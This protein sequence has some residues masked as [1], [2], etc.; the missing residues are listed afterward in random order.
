[1]PQEK[2]KVV[3]DCNVYLQ[4]F[5]SAKGTAG[6]RKKLVD[7]GLIELY[8]SRDIFDEVSNVLARPEFQAKFSHATPEAMADFIEKVN[9]V[10]IFVR[11]VDEH[12]DEI[13]LF[14]PKEI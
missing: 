13:R 1:M 5:L 7:D 2:P 12:I 8:I 4:A 14:V 3:F 6:K 10:A 9:D 11:K